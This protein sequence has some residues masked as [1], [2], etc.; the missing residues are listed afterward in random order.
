MG[1]TVG[2]AFYEC[3]EKKKASSHLSMETGLYIISCVILY[4]FKGLDGH[5]IF[6]FQFRYLVYLRDKTI[7]QFLDF[8]F[9]NF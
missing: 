5:H 1:L 4:T 7:S 3:V 6:L 9:S 8:T 2:L